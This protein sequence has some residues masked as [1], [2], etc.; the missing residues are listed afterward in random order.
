[1]SPCFRARKE[2]REPLG[3]L[4]GDLTPEVFP[5]NPLVPAPCPLAGQSSTSKRGPKF[6]WTKRKQVRRGGSPTVPG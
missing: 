3:T 5:T 1:M 4:L 2:F 6:S